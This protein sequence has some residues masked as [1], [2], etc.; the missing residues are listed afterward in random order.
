V[1]ELVYRIRGGGFDENNDPVA[2]APKVR[3]VAKAVQPG[4][5]SA[6]VQ[7]GRDPSS[8]ACSVF[9]VG[10]VDLDENTDRLEVRGEQYRIHIDDWRSAFNT[11][12]RGMVALCRL[13]KG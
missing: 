3:L 10:A 7:V 6:S 13:G 9:F 1:S 2:V 11:G 5:Y 8:Y 12:R 4:A